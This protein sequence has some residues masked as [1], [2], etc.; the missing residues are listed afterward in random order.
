MNTSL[1][2]LGGASEVGRLGTLLENDD[3]QILIDYG[4]KPDNP[5]QFPMPAP[6]VDSLLLTHAHLDH[7][8]LTPQI[9]SSGS[10]ICSTPLT[11]RLAEVLAKDT[12]KI[13]KQEG[14]QEPFT[15]EAILE[16]N[17]NHFAHKLNKEYYHSGFSYKSL[18]AGHIPGAVMYHFPD[19]DFLFTGDINTINTGLTRA[20]KPIS[21]KT[22]A[23]ESTY[24]G[25][26]HEDR[27]TIESHF[28]DSVEDVINRGGQVVLPA[29]ALGRSQELLMLLR[30][31]DIDIWLDGMGREIANIFSS[32]PRDLRNSGLYFDTLKRTKFVRSWRQR[33]RAAKGDV[34]VTTAG[35]LEGGPV[36]HYLS[37]IRKDENSAMFITGYQAEGTNGRALLETGKARL[38][39]NKKSPH[40]DIDCQI[41]KFDLSG[42]A[43]HT[44]LID[45][46]DKCQPDNVILFHGDNREELAKDL[47]NYN[48][49]LPIEGSPLNIGSN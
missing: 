49:H 23:I 9:A 24:A 25:R 29:F 15:K 41:K 40:F 11:I 12:L 16:Q 6:R 17:S 22:I 3:G 42:H 47:T 45:F 46:I 34:I 8:G 30:K 18:N 48:V 39:R 44:Q 33:E 32:Y 35:M 1:T 38:D 5:P 13:S 43:D 37:K 28:V 4:L 31:L 2:F 20:A 10:P 27:S 14:Y 7:S 21:C 19:L 36:M 26:N